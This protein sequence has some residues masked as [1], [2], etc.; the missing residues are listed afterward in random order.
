MVCGWVTLAPESQGPLLEKITGTD[1]ATK[2][3]VDE[4][5]QVVILAGEHK[6]NWVSC[7]I[8]TAGI[9]HQQMASTTVYDIH[10]LETSDFS[11]AAGAS[12]TDVKAV[13]TGHL[14]KSRSATPGV[15]TV[16]GCPV[17]EF[18]GAYMLAGDHQGLPRYEGPTLPQKYKNGCGNLYYDRPSWRWRLSSKFAPLKTN[19]LAWTKNDEGS[20]P[21]GAVNWRCFSKGSWGDHTFTIAALQ[22]GDS[23]RLPPARCKLLAEFFA[24]VDLLG[25]ASVDKSDPAGTGVLPWNQQSWWDQHVPGW[26]ADEERASPLK[27]VCPKCATSL[28]SVPSEFVTEM[29]PEVEVVCDGEGC[30]NE[31]TLADMAA[32]GFCMCPNEECDFGICTGCQLP[33][34]GGQDVGVETDYSRAFGPSWTLEMDSALVEYSSERAVLLGKSSPGKLALKELFADSKPEAEMAVGE[35]VEIFSKSGQAWLPARVI[36]VDGLTITVSYTSLSG[37]AMEKTILAAEGQRRL[38]TLV[39]SH[40]CRRANRRPIGRR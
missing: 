8:L 2:F 30:S 3:D 40:L 23:S 5:A 15:L 11:N 37:A 4:I 19:C 22:A 29:G 32:A 9:A 21:L 13:R 34:Q 1:S 33:R 10:V 24:L 35:S 25:P 18:N 38:V 26:K 17:V 16:S 6:D 12:D 20:V 28:T 14:R 31:G 27:L 39:A 7:R 36:T